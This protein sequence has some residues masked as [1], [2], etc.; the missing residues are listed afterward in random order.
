MS[1]HTRDAGLA[2]RWLTLL[3]FTASRHWPFK[4]FMR[5]YAI[6]TAFN[7]C[8]KIYPFENL[9]E[10]HAMQFVAQHT[11]I[12]VPKVHC[13]FTHKGSTFIVMERIKGHQVRQGWQERSDESRKKI[14][15]QLRQMVLELRSVPAPQGTSISNVDGGPF[16][17][18]RLPDKNYWGPYAT[19]RAFHNALVNDVDIDG[20]NLSGLPEDI[21]QLLRFYQQYGQESQ[22]LVFTHGDL[23]SLNILVRGDAVVGIIDWETSGWLPASWEHVCAKNVNPYNLFWSEE[24]DHFITPMV[25]ELEMDRIRLNHFAF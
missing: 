13:A 5:R 23:S 3:V 16:F 8:I 12:P 19:K 15:E 4:S 7:F 9:G 1:G 17:D 2:A 20:A 21:A 18:P 6:L 22:E 11:S 14:L 24:V 25:R 10:A